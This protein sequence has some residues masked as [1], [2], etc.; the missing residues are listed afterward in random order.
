MDL[1]RLGF[2]LHHVSLSSPSGWPHASTVA[3]WTRKDDVPGVRRPDWVLALPLTVWI[4]TSLCFCLL[5]CQKRVPPGDAPSSPVVLTYG[6]SSSWGMPWLSSTPTAL[7]LVVETFSVTAQGELR[8]Q[9]PREE[10]WALLGPVGIPFTVEVV[11]QVKWSTSQVAQL[12]LEI[13]EKGELCPGFP[14]S[15]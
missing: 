13:V 1:K 7:W 6:D 15:I 9:S 8:R 10:P 12:C 14:S 3:G 4:L 2:W 5:A 11:L